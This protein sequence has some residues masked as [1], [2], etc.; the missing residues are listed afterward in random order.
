MPNLGMFPL[1][2]TL[3]TLATQTTN[4][5]SA[6]LQ[7]Q[8]SD[9]YRFIVEVKTVSGTSPTL[10]VFLATGDDGGP[11]TTATNYVEFLHFAQMTTTGQGRQALIRPYLGFGDT[12]TEQA[13][14]L[15]G[16]VDG[17]TGATAVTTNGPFDP[18]NVKVRWVIGGTSPSFAFAIKVIGVPADPST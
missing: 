3:V 7:V 1:V 14:P 5:T 12:A 10:D 9:S 8:Q 4:G 15:L 6:N 11:N 17:A 2:Q 13:A 18:T 16:T